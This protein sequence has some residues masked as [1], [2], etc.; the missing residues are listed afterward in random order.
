MLRKERLEIISTNYLN[1]ILPINNFSW[2]LEKY[3]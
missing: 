3:K 1:I 2:V